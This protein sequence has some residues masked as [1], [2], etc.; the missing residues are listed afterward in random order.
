MA[1]DG[2]VLK[3]VRGALLALLAVFKSDL[4][5]LLARLAF[6]KAS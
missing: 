4:S 6:S 5:A 2:E 3:S 1:Q